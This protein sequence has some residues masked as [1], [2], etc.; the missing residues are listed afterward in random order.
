MSEGMKETFGSEE[1]ANQYKE[2][3]QLLG[4]V[5]QQLAGDGRWGLVFP[6]E[7]H[8]EVRQPH[9]RDIDETPIGE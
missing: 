5:A 3:H 7:C 8:V 6:L 2:Q 4:R 9:A 1:E